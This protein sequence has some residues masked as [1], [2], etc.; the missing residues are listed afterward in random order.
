MRYWAR[1]ACG[2][3]RGGAA[4]RVPEYARLRGAA[5][6]A[7]GAALLLAA[8]GAALYAARRR[9]RRAAARREPAPRAAK[10]VR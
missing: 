8:L 7:G 10:R 9:L 2:R 4:L 5:A 1:V 3:A 6:G